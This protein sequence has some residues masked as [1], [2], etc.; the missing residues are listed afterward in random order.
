MKPATE[1]KILELVLECISSDSDCPL[2]TGARC[3]YVP[4]AVVVELARQIIK[5]AKEEA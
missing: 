4:P 2:G 3:T 5:I 1:R